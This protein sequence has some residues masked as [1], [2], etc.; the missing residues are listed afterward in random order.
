M[1]TIFAYTDAHGQI[2]I[3]EINEYDPVEFS[4]GVCKYQCTFLP[5]KTGMYQVATR[6]FAK[7]PKMPHRQD[8]ECV[9]WL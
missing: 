9:K 4:D 7:N 5:D 6:V 2:H 3:S 1:E 8:F